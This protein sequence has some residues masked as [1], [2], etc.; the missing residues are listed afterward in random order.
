[1]RETAAAYRAC[2]SYVLSDR[3]LQV[4]DASGDGLVAMF[5]GRHQI[6]QCPGGLGRWMAGERTRDNQACSYLIPPSSRRLGSALHAHF[7][8]TGDFFN[9]TLMGASTSKKVILRHMESPKTT[10]ERAFALAPSGR[11][12]SLT[13][14]MKTLTLEGYR[15][16][17]VERSFA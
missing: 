3:H 9:L 11:C 1:M 10:I 5:P 12:G 14:V 17:S 13:D 6:Q 15:F 4:V 16:G 7:M 8:H 2:H